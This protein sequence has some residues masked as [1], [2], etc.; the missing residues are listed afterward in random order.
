MNERSSRENTYK[1]IHSWQKDMKGKY[2][3]KIKKS[4]GTV[5]I[6]TFKGSLNRILM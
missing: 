5:N 6:I 1:Q 2:K 3:K 4:D